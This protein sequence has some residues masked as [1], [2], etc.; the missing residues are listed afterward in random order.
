MTKHKAFLATIIA[1]NQQ[2]A[3][4]IG[5]FANKQ[6]RSDLPGKSEEEVIISG[7]LEKLYAE[8]CSIAQNRG[9]PRTTNKIILS[10]WASFFLPIRSLTSIVPNGYFLAA[11]MILYL[12]TA[13]I[14]EDALQRKFPKNESS[15][16]NVA[17]LHSFLAD[18]DEELLRCLRALWQSSNAL[19]GFPWV[20]THYAVRERHPDP[21]KAAS[22]HAQAVARSPAHLAALG[23]INGRRIWVPEPGDA[24]V[25][26]PDPAATG[27]AFEKA[28]GPLLWQEYGHDGPIRQEFHYHIIDED[29]NDVQFRCRDV[30]RRSRQFILD[31]HYFTRIRLAER[32]LDSSPLA[33]ETKVQIMGYLD[34]P[35]LEPYL[36]KLN[37]ADVYSPFPA[38][39][40]HLECLECKTNTRHKTN[41]HF[42]L[43][44]PHKSLTIWN[45][46]LRTFHTFH[47]RSRLA[48][49][50]WFLCRHMPCQGHHTGDDA[51][52]WIVL[53]E[54]EF[55]NVLDGIVS[56][57]C[58]PGT[59]LGSVGF[60]PVDEIT[61]SSE[62]ADEE[63]QK[64]LFGH[65]PPTGGA[66]E[67]FSMKGGLAGLAHAM[68]HG[69]T[70]LGCWQGEGCGGETNTDAPW[71][72]G[73]TLSD[74][75]QAQQALSDMVT[76]GT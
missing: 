39:D 22:R 27:W 6:Q 19:E 40:K 4:D 43:T 25:Y 57:R 38:V 28:E 73:R 49:D 76:R 18:L 72:R 11:R 52:E 3:V 62:E 71:A 32:I 17:E 58:G 2:L 12:A 9:H 65:R 45:L 21:A 74:E 33:T 48:T 35:V 54:D 75:R 59:N 31:S 44:C 61:L 1:K 46:V 20:F 66:D 30:F 70:M 10:A 60:G 67:D 29:R 23:G 8:I 55:R 63:R 51:H 15:I 14:S 53:Y 68:R 7:F 69:K 13:F 26:Q 56:D 47:P 5:T 16:P 34:D 50:T 42:K 37:L 36:S 64:R 41:L 24:P